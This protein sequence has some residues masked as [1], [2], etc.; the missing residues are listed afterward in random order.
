MIIENKADVLLVEPTCGS[1]WD[2]AAGDAILRS[3]GG[4]IYFENYQEV[5]V[6]HIP[7]IKK[8]KPFNF[9]NSKIASSYSSKNSKKNFLKRYSPNGCR[10]FLQQISLCNA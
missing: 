7:Y 2:I 5:F 4:G 9:Q 8:K 6:F 3:L 1:R 10:F